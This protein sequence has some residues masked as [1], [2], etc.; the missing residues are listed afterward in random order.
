MCLL[1]GQHMNGHRGANVV[2][3]HAGVIS[4]ILSVGVR[5][6][7]SA[8]RSASAR[9]RFDAAKQKTQLASAVRGTLSASTP[10]AL[11]VRLLVHTTR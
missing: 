5:N 9:I 3:Q 10:N 2:A 11:R 8:H 7:Q 1:T 4:G 6:E